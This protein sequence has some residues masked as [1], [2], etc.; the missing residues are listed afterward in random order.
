MRLAKGDCGVACA[1]GVV[2]TSR[3]AKS[4]FGEANRVQNSKR[5]NVNALCGLAHGFGVGEG[6]GEHL[7]KVGDEMR[8]EEIG[9]CHRGG[10]K[11]DPAERNPALNSR[12]IP[13]GRN[14]VNLKGKEEIDLAMLLITL[15][16]AIFGNGQELG[17]AGIAAHLFFNLALKCKAR[18]LAEFDMSAGQITPPALFGLTH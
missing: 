14:T 2:A 1:A 9:R 5:V 17:R 3:F 10:G 6:A 4:A 15:K 13:L 12:R 11:V 18:R 7:G 16:E 8:G